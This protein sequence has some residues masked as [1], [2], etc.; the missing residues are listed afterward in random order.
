MRGKHPFSF[1]LAAAICAGSSELSSTPAAAQQAN[2][3]QLAPRLQPGPSAG[4]GI[5]PAPVELIQTPPNAENV[6]VN[7]R[8]VVLEG[9]FPELSEQTA[10]LT[11]QIEGQRVSLAKIYEL[12]RALQ[13]A[14]TNRFPLARVKPP[15]VDVRSGVVR[16][17]ITDG[18][19]ERVDLD[20][21]PERA[22][23]L[24]IGRLEPLLNRRHLT[25]E[26][27][28]RQILLLEDI[29]GLI[30]TT[31]G[32]LGS[33]PDGSVLVIQAVDKLFTAA[34]SVDNRLSK[35]L[36]T[37]EFTDT[38]AINNA[39]G[40]GEQFYGTV[41]SSADFGRFFQGRA[42]YQAWGA[43]VTL[44]LGF[45]GLKTEAG[46]LSV[47]QT[48]T[49][50]PGSLLP[51][52]E[53]IGERTTARFQ[54]AYVNAVYPLIL[55]VEQSLRLQGT[56]DYTEEGQRGGPAPIGFALPVGW[57]F[58]FYRDRYS[59]FRLAT[60]WS[61]RFPWEWGGRAATTAIYSHG[62]GGRTAWNAPLVGMSL[63]RNGAG[64]VFDRLYVDTRIV[65]PLPDGFEALLI[66]RAQTSFGQSLML[67][68]QF[69][70]DGLNA[71]SGFAAGTINV[72]RGVTVRS[73][74]SRGFA[75]DLTSFGLGV[76]A[77]SVSPYIFG[78]WGGGV[79]E[80]PFVGEVK[81][82]EAESFGGG[83]RTGSS[84]I[85]FPLGGAF[86]I[87]FAKSYSNLPFR[88]SGYRTNV[89]FVIKF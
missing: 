89:S 13:A 5:G 11:A 88:R 44:P 51:W 2:P 35:Y 21:V 22:R 33:T 87:E 43:G 79:R 63:S 31:S 32:R 24:V 55:T 41:A 65:Q 80:W 72:D 20:N 60:E 59:T 52:Q 58:D 36:G 34:K 70:I 9:A 54:R 81:H 40:F 1:F 85:D 57:I 62:L 68:E 29:P 8:K 66:A 4:I 83:L 25:L 39:L 42:K 37:W 6:F 73:E 26:E 12:A 48:P 74:L 82:V 56:Y 71:V 47:Y 18:F 10:L 84:L 69:S 75:L 67:A 45:D 38:A 86:N 3:A 16:L 78:A 50:L 64:P 77:T 7:V 61:I 46:Y 53:V 28:Q 14:Y 30:G 76:G 49:P 23:P 19:I 15:Q 17:A 27:I